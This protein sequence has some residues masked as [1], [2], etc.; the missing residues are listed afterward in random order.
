[1]IL[2]IKDGK[3]IAYHED[4]QDVL[5]KYPNCAIIKV[6]DEEVV[7]DEEGWPQMPQSGIDLRKDMDDITF[8]KESVKELQEKLKASEKFMF[9]F[10][11]AERIAQKSKNAKLS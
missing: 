9:D 10:D 5:D 1:M 3:V 11:I 2:V 6:K 7:F 4:G 8:L